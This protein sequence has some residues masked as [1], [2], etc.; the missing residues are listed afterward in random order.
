MPTFIPAPTQIEAAGNKSKI[1]REH[2]G[3]VNSSTSD[4]SIAH[5]TSPAG[6][7][8]PG[9]TPEFEEYTLALRG[10]LRVTHKGREIDVWPGQAVITHPGEWV[11]HSRPECAD[12]IAVRLP[13]F[14]A[15][16]V[17]RDS[18]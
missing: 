9:Q 14:S 15:G 17:H 10:M 1:I 6:W 5:M 4:V 18:Q 7:V 13:A 11:R 8:E 16:A 3:R 2:I 12:Y